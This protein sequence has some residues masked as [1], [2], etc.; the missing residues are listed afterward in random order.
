M[1]MMDVVFAEQLIAQEQM[2]RGET[3]KVLYMFGKLHW[4]MR[5]SGG[6]LT[7]LQL[8]IRHI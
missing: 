7:G 4:H 3:A 8:Y 1:E 6:S 2:A 5:D